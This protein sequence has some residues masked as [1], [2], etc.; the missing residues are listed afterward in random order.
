MVVDLEFKDIYSVLFRLLI[1]IRQIYLISFL[2][3]FYCIQQMPPVV[4]R[5]MVTIEIFYLCHVNMTALCAC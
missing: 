4:V 3:L 2:F 5:L 1:Y